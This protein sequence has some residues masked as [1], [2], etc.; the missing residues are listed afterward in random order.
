MIFKKKKNNN[1]NTHTLLHKFCMKNNPKYI[2]SSLKSYPF[3]PVL[4][5]FDTLFMLRTYSVQ[6]WKITLFTWIFGW[7]WYPPWHSSAPP[8]KKICVL[9]W[10]S[11][12][13]RFIH[14]MKSLIPKQILHNL[15]FWSENIIIFLKLN[16]R[17]FSW[18]YQNRTK[19][20][21]LEE[22]KLHCN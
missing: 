6:L 1:N 11:L 12:R 9:F 18:L 21:K 14:E 19:W 5:E 8:G 13:H 15:F 16:F 22:Q 10:I 2:R 3:R 7:A 4:H 17:K 20:N